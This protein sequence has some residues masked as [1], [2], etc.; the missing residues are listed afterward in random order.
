MAKNRYF[1]KSLIVNGFRFSYI[2]LTL[3]NDAFGLSELCFKALT[4]GKWAAQMPQMT[5]S[6]TTNDNLKGHK[7]QIYQQKVKAEKRI[8]KD[9]LHI[10]FLEWMK[11]LTKICSDFSKTKSNK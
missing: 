1:R 9:S 4:C 11:K 2:L 5:R 8:S 10:S 6:K 3:K 7:W